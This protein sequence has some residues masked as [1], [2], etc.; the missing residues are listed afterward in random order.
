MHI[1]INIGFVSVFPDTCFV[2]WDPMLEDFDSRRNCYEMNIDDAEIAA[3]GFSKYSL[4]SETFSFFLQIL[5]Y[6]VIAGFQKEELFL[7]CFILTFLLKYFYNQY[8]LCSCIRADKDGLSFHFSL[9]WSIF[10]VVFELEDL[11]HWI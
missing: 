11:T 10:F 5:F 9:D 1:R 6:N 7:S 4:F 8:K 3:V 2:N